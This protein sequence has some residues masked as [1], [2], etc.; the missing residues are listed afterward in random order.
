MSTEATLNIPTHENPIG[1]V[2][3][4]EKPVEAQIS[5]EPKKEEE[6]ALA[7][8]FAALAKK[9]KLAQ[10]AQARLKAERA[11]IEKMRQEVESFNKYKSEAKANPLKALE[12][13]GLKYDDLVNYVLNGEK[14]TPEQEISMVKSEIQKF[15][16]EQERRE[17]EKEQ[18]AKLEAEKAYEDTIN[19]F[20]AKVTEH[21]SSN[22]D[23]YE[24]IAMH[25]AEGLIFDT[26]EEYFNTSGKIMAIDK[27]AELVEGYLEEQVESTLQKSKKFKAKLEKK[28]EP[29][30][31]ATAK[32]PSPT[33]NNTVAT[34]TAAA[35]FLSPKT[36][37]ERIQRALAKLSGA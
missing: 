12:S 13:M 27:A 28:E 2:P 21:V 1:E 14:P 17:L 18:Q 16:E 3:V 35:S 31:G 25:E 37:Q 29:K 20:K 19:S 26:I 8:K 5:L 15:R 11:E 23:K 30:A 36:E 4:V 9:A 24:L 10:Q 32:A 33:L 34:S 7:P 22:P 6:P